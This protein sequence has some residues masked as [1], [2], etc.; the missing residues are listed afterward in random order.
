MFTTV[1]VVNI[2]SAVTAL[3]FNVVIA[4][5]WKKGLAVDAIIHSSH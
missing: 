4:C 2:Y 1:N 3:L 5:Q